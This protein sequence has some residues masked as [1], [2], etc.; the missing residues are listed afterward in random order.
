MYD[1][2]Y[3]KET[4]FQDTHTNLPWSLSVPDLP[5]YLRLRSGLCVCLSMTAAMKRVLLTV[6]RQEKLGETTENCG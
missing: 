5:Q 4:S 3:L 1:N 2:L 6:Q